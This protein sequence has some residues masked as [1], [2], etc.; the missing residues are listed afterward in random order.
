VLQDLPNNFGLNRLR[1]ALQSIEGRRTAIDVGAHKGIWTRV[2]ME[3]FDTVYSFEPILSNFLPLK[4]IN[5]NSY[6]IGIGE[7]A[8]IAYFE[9]G[10]NTGMWHVTDE[11]TEHTSEI[12]R[13]DDYNF[14]NVDFIK[15]DVEG[16][17]LHVLKGA[18]DTITKN[19]PA[20]LLEENGL[21]PR[22]N[23]THN[24]LWKYMKTLG[25]KNVTRF[26]DDFLWLSK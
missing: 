5:P 11:I 15:I 23:Q 8:S 16:Y 12:K 2:M 6:N 7:E 17:E 26:Q 10:Y 24:E 13:L 1:G 22:Y 25:Y 19:K 3:E 14:D 9:P 18:I 21:L 4:D 20:I